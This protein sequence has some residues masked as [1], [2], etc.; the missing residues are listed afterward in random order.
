MP[1]WTVNSR[2]VYQRPLGPTEL[3][4]QFFQNQSSSTDMLQNATVEVLPENEGMFSE[5]PVI[6]AWVAL[7]QKFPLLGAQ[8]KQ[9]ETGLVFVVEKQWLVRPTEQEI[10]FLT[11]PSIDAINKL[12]HE[13]QNESHL[14]SDTVLSRLFIVTRSDNPCCFH[15]LFLTA[16]CIT[17][18]VANCS[19]ARNFLSFLCDSSHDSDI[20]DRLALS[21]TA[22]DLN[23]AT[24]LSLARQR[25]RKAIAR[26]LIG[27][28]DSN[29]KG[30]QT[31]PK[32]DAVSK[33]ALSSRLVA[34]FSP[35]ESSRIIQTCRNLGITFNT[36]YQVL[37]HIAFS[38]ILCQRRVQNQMSSEEWDF[39]KKEPVHS[40]GP[41]N[42]RPY[43]DEDW[44]NQGG[45]EMVSAA[46]SFSRC[47]L[48][49]IPLDKASELKPGDTVLG[50]EDLLSHERFRHRCTEVQ[51]QITKQLKHPLAQEIT[52]ANKV[53][54]LQRFKSSA[55]YKK[56]PNAVTAFACSSFGKRDGF[57]PL[58]YPIQGS[59][60]LRL[61]S[62]DVHLRCRPGEVYLGAL[63]MRRQL[64]LIV[65]WD[66]NVY[67]YDI[68]GLWH[69]EVKKAV[70]HYLLVEV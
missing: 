25:W 65:Y 2:G 41:V 19:I 53:T 44:Y 64:Q 29:L 15:V 61:L 39:R 3:L 16:H 26:V 66:A 58:E 67:S 48:P 51:L 6:Q 36:A 70:E 8:I 40:G 50:F 52:A 5:T 46:I 69:K 68:I 57:L 32:K 49:F 22:E 63:T 10:T 27:L 47:V 23:P 43:L 1:S 60:K 11:L 12:I 21:I 55:V 59:L 54:L 33:P 20:E 4:F 17:D 35:E 56:F 62:A 37:S 34:T 28:S 30:G 13:I 14:L 38:R 24:K 31:L 42:L 18:G 7:K 45:S 9:D